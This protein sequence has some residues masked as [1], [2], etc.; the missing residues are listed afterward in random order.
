MQ[1]V[2]KQLLD[3]DRKHIQKQIDDCM[4]KI[5]ALEEQIEGYNNKLSEIEKLENELNEYKKRPVAERTMS[6]YISKTSA[7]INIMDR[8]EDKNEKGFKKYDRMVVKNIYHYNDDYSFNLIIERKG[9]K[10]TVGSITMTDFKLGQSRSLITHAKEEIRK[11]T[12]ENKTQ[13]SDGKEI[14][15]NLPYL[16][17]A[18]NSSNRTGYGNIY[19]GE[20]LVY[21][22]TLYGETTSYAF[23]GVIII[24]QKK[25]E[26]ERQRKLEQRRAEYAERR[27]K[28]SELYEEQPAISDTHIRPIT[29]KDLLCERRNRKTF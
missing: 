1:T 8:F 17:R 28:Q 3:F 12:E 13:L 11:A 19:N 27:R 6:T 20:S 22:G 7:T 14:M 5:K 29:I 10:A 23:T 21:E 2:T 9:D 18:Q 25:R 24:D 26:D 4:S 16:L 15:F